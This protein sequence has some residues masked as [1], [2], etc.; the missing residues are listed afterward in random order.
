VANLVEFLHMVAIHLCG[1]KLKS[2]N[3]ATFREIGSSDMDAKL[4][5]YGTPLGKVSMPVAN[6]YKYRQ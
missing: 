4:P 6:G 5:H 1:I 2:R 3:P